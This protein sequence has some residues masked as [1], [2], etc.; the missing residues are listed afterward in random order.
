MRMFL[1]V[2]TLE[3]KSSRKWKFPGHFA[4]GS[5]SSREQIGQGPIGRFAPGSE[6]ARERKGSLASLKHKRHDQQ[7]I[8][9]P[10]CI[11]CW[12]CR[13]CVVEKPMKL[14]PMIQPHLRHELVLLSLSD[15]QY[16]VDLLDTTNNIGHNYIGL[17]YSLVRFITPVLNRK[18]SLYTPAITIPTNHAKHET[19]Y[20]FKNILLL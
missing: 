13:L 8:Q 7:A 19:I 1:G 4:P 5:E 14:C 20:R 18:K 17:L 2:N 16:I 3:C 9:E 11:A 10:D 12:S 6:L 15:L